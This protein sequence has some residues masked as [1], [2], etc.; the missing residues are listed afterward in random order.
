MKLNQI[1]V[2]GYQKLTHID[3]AVRAPIL[4]VTGA[5]EA[6][7]TSL[8]DAIRHAVL[9]EGGRIKLQKDFAAL[10]NDDFKKGVVSLEWERNGQIGSASVVVP[11]GTRTCDLEPTPIINCL[12]DFRYFSNMPLGLRR[13]LLF[14]LGKVRVTGAVIRDKLIE[15]GAN[16]KKVETIA[17]ILLAGFEA[18][19]KEAKAKVSESRGAWKA[20]TNEVYGSV[21]AEKWEAAIP[22]WSQ[23]AIDEGA[24]L[25]SMADEVLAQANMDIG[26]LQ[27]Q[28]RAAD[29]A[30]MDIQDLRQKAGMV[31]RI[32]AKLK[33]DETDLAEW[34]QKVADA[35]AKATGERPVKPM[36]C[37]HCD[38]P[39]LLEAGVLVKYERPTKEA[40]P[41]ALLQL[42]EFEKSLDK[43][44]GW[45]TNDHRDLA[46]ATVAQAALAALEAKPL[47]IISDDELGVE[48]KR[49]RTLQDGLTDA[50]KAHDAAVLACTQATQAAATTIKAHDFHE[51]TK[52]WDEIAG[53]L[54]PEGIP[55]NMMATAM[56]PIRERL[57]ATAQATGWDLVTVE[58][59][60]TVRIGGRAYALGSQ[61]AKWRAD[62]AITEAIASLS[63]ERFFM[64]DEVDV[65]DS[66]NR[67]VFLKWMHGLAASKQIET[68]LVSGT[69]KE[70]PSCPGTFQVEWIQNGA[71]RVPLQAVA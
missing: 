5:N 27:E 47:K 41:E 49:I 50:R 66:P 61:S 51:D 48:R 38:T 1:T 6:G 29:K 24:A 60:M 21:K 46:A 37:P 34:T 71:L 69:F 52:E 16:A 53:L 12:V 68:A 14:T 19:A 45:V 36:D 25:C 43:V 67:L 7:K 28:K 2:E 15:A 63:G 8:A 56:S 26:A 54:A 44:Q 23:K 32:K 39:L 55:S 11:A 3:L 65:L 10:V 64:V 42:P 17:P 33:Q 30:A 35:Q 20:T 59:D 18:A 13:G 4:F 62:V 70:P 22:E 40:D 57:Q 58:D 31:D 9:G